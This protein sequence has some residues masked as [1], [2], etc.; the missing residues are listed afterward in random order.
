MDIALIAHGTLPD[1]NACE[2]SFELT[3]KELEVNCLSTISLLTHL[4]NHFEQQKSGSIVVLSSV[5]EDRGRQSNYVYGAAK[6][7]VSVFLQGLR[8]RLH[9][10]EVR[11]ITIK[12]GF[13]DTP[14]TAGFKKGVLWSQPE[15]VGRVVHRLSLKK[16]GVFYVPWFWRY[17]MLM[18]R[19]I[20]ENIFKRLKL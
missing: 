8:S 10:S 14:M 3:R 6:G 1:Q 11:V 12:L 9:K 2:N 15:K 19:I 18:I 4:G 7:A 13:V 20:P 16:N 5:A 17:V